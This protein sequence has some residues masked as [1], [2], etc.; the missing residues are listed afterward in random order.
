MKNSDEQI[1]HVGVLAA[2]YEHGSQRVQFFLAELPALAVGLRKLLDVLKQNALLGLSYLAH[3]HNPCVET[4]F[5]SCG[6]H[7]G[8]HS[9]NPRPRL[10]VDYLQRIERNLMACTKP[11]PSCNSAPTE[12]PVG[13]RP[14]KVDENMPPPLQG[15]RKALFQVL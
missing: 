11:P 6:L 5:C 4:R 15:V 1:H 9:L 7:L 14:L 10:F 3:L 2:V 13:A 8:N 12:R